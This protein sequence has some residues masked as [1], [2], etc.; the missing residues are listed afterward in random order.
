MS[1]DQVWDDETAALYAQREKA[2]EKDQLQGPCEDSHEVTAP[3]IGMLPEESDKT[4]GSPLN[5]IDTPD[6]IF[7]GI[8]AVKPPP[9]TQGFRWVNGQ[10]V[11]D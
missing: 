3:F 6:P 2:H 9:K 11:R 7:K 8:R 10:P 1:E 5:F 4:E